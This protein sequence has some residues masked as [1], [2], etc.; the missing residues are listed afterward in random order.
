MLYNL[1]ELFN[2]LVSFKCGVRHWDRV[3]DVLFVGRHGC[4]SEGLSS[5]RV[6]FR[7][8][9]RAVLTCTERMHHAISKG[10]NPEF[11][12]QST[13]ALIPPPAGPA[14]KRPFRTCENFTWISPENR[15]R[16]STP[17]YTSKIG[18]IGPV[19]KIQ[20]CRPTPPHPPRRV[21]VGR[22]FVVLENWGKFVTRRK[23][24]CAS[25]RLSTRLSTCMRSFARLML[26]ENVTI[27]SNLSLNKFL[28][29]ML[30]S[31]TSIIRIR[32][33]P[34]DWKKS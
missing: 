14:L 31:R 26:R 27:L 2:F 6:V 11:G 16:R 24:R 29:F 3:G 15:I 1:V 4:W 33:D 13:R 34:D 10:K 17:H 28:S 7:L 20:K 23:R 9:S 21:T 18:N 8:R 25:V 32:T 30:Y 19:R 12:Q 5:Q 22:F